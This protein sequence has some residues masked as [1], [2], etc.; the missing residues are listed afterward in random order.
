MLLTA[1]VLT[2]HVIILNDPQAII[3]MNIGKPLESL[4]FNGTCKYVSIVILKHR[5]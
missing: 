1:H 2:T 5:V 3:L 4:N